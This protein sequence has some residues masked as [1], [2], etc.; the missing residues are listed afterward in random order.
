M[1]A[2]YTFKCHAICCC[3]F[4]KMRKDEDQK[5]RE[6]ISLSSPSSSFRN[7]DVVNDMGTLHWKLKSYW[8]CLKISW[9]RYILYGPD[10][11]QWT[12]LN[13]NTESVLELN[14]KLKLNWKFQFFYVVPKYFRCPNWVKSI[15]DDP[16]QN[17][18][19]RYRHVKNDQTSI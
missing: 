6:N 3:D 7:Q 17:V 8:S 4:Y 10:H 1:F 11:L 13:W 19:I 12:I 16:A 2:N 15:A 9:G 5:E 14:K 18:Y